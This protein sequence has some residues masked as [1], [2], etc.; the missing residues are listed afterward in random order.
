[1]VVPG[2]EG[3]LPDRSAPISEFVVVAAG[4]GLEVLHK[5]SG[6][7]AALLSVLQNL[8]YHWCDR[9]PPVPSDGA[10]YL[11]RLRAGEAVLRRRTWRLHEAELAALGQAATASDALV[12][13]AKLARTL[14]LPTRIF[15]K[16]SHEPKPVFIDLESALSVELL[17]KL[18]RQ[19]AWL[20]ITEVLPDRDGLWLDVDGGL[21]TS[22]LRFTYVLP[23][24]PWRA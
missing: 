24:A 21:R 7:R 2:T 12:A 13:A 6:T 23:E 22:E 4:A 3:R 14:R 16:S 11:P 1:V 20:R 5:P 15:V 17:V 19:A 8:L 10:D 9:V 18:A